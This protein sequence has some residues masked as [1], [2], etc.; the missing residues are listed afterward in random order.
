MKI[1][2]ATP[3]HIVRL[4]VTK[5][6]EETFYINLCE[7]EQDDAM[8]YV[9]KL[10]DNEKLSAF[11]IGNRTRVDFRDCI[12]GKNGKSKAISFRGL[13]PKETHSLIINSI[14]I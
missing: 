9:K 10:I 7:V 13:S 8:E 12:G 11:Q 2:K 1:Y 3:L 6:G 4:T 5:L 14:K